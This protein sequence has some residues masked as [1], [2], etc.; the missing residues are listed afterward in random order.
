M[1]IAQ[2]VKHN[3]TLKGCFLV[4][5]NVMVVLAEG[6]FSVSHSESMTWSHNGSKVFIFSN[7]LQHPKIRCKMEHPHVGLIHPGLIH[8]TEDALLSA[9]DQLLLARPFASNE[10]HCSEEQRTIVKDVALLAHKHNRCVF[11]TI[12][13]DQNMFCSGS[14]NTSFCFEQ[15]HNKLCN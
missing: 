15:S 5:R 2:N 10:E 12:G 14:F 7:L 4:N 1:Q 13:C 8:G 6:I 9:Q 11:Q 3:G